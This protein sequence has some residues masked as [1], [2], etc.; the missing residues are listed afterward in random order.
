LTKEEKRLKNQVFREWLKVGEAEE[1]L[2][3]LKKVLDK[4]GG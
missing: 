3:F 4:D 2:I 1:V